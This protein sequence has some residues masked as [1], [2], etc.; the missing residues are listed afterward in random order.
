MEDK[1]KQQIQ[2]ALKLISKERVNTAGLGAPINIL[3]R[4]LE[5]S[6]HSSESVPSAQEY[7]KEHWIEFSKV[8]EIPKIMESYKDLCVEQ[9]RNKWKK[10]KRFSVDEICQILEE[11]TNFSGKAFKKYFEDG[12]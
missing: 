2:E 4:L 12:K 3:K 6:E 5:D 9:E 1:T 10:E 7:Y 11:K 8:T